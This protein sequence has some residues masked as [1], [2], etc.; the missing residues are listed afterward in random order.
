MMQLPSDPRVRITTPA[1]SPITDKTALPVRVPFVGVKDGW[2]ERVAIGVTL[3]NGRAGPS[4]FPPSLFVAGTMN[5]ARWWIRQSGTESSSLDVGS[6]SPRPCTISTNSMGFTMLREASTAIILKRITMRPK[7]AVYGAFFAVVAIAMGTKAQGQR[8]WPNRPISVV[9]PF[10]VGTTYDIVAH[11]VLDPVG[12]QIGQSFVL[13]S[14][15]G[16]GGT[17]GV[18]SVVGAAPDGY[19]LLLSSSAMSVA[20]I[21][22][23]SLPYDEVRDLEPVAM[24][25]GEPSMLVGAPGK[26]INSVAGLV[27][28][29]KANPGQVRFA[30]V[31]I[32]SASYIAGERFS[33]M[34]GLNVQHVPYLGP[35]E[36]LADLTAGRI[37]FYFIPVTPAIPLIDEGKV[38]PLAVSTPNRLQSLSGLP[39]L[40][41]SG[42]PVAA[43]LT[44]CGLSAPAKTPR[45][46]IDKLNAAIVKVVNL[47]AV[48]TKLLRIGFEPETM[49]PEQYGKFFADDVAAMVK[50]GNDAHIPPS[51]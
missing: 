5:R 3:T 7:R 11:T 45:D 51:D 26:G 29:A 42:F 33:L 47:P 12:A 6:L 16:G 14:R 39:T 21:L 19:T 8:D 43:Y 24:F 50:L 9:S 38:V 37:D 31:G 23:K 4:L 30:S 13:E 1:D 18:A 22:H 40:A 36:A 32:G 34:A 28:A 35:A 44:W 46:I 2:S 15:P 49:S 27:A 10:A 41:E 20:V 48:R 17:T 25:G